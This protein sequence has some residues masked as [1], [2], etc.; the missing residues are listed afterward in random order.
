MSKSKSQKGSIGFVYG[1]NVLKVG[2]VC[3]F[4]SDESKPEGK[5]DKL[6][7]GPTEDDLKRSP[8]LPKLSVGPYVSCRYVPCENQTKMFDA[9]KQK[10]AEHHI[11]QDLY[12]V[13]S[14][15]VINIMKEIT[16]SKTV[17]KLSAEAK[18][19][20]D[21]TEMES[22]GEVKDKRSAKRAKA[23]SEAEDKEPTP[24]KEVK[25]EVKK[26]VKKSEPKPEPKR[27]KPENEEEKKPTPKGKKEEKKPVP[28]K[29]P[30]D[31]D[32]DSNSDSGS[33]SDD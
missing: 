29:R 13:Y 28:V 19:K 33:D 8:D 2:I 26:D 14:T 1:G 21:E 23:E 4:V 5:F 30:V 17:H 11:S 16:G 20:K 9:L 15:T 27:A 32:S 7:K 10:L 24:K 6:K 18:E 22:E 12:G 3:L 25:K 31:S